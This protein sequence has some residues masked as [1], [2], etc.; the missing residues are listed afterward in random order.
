MARVWA[1]ARP[2]KKDGRCRVANPAGSRAE[3]WSP[4]PAAGWQC[5]VPRGGLA[6]GRWPRRKSQAA[7]GADLGLGVWIG[8]V[9]QGLAALVAVGPAAVHGIPF[10][11]A[12]GVARGRSFRGGPRRGGSGGPF[13]EFLVPLGLGLGS[14]G[15]FLGGTGV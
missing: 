6:S 5:E 1:G 14:G 15:G 10:D 3:P 7:A 8:R 2:R 11:A 13:V 12:L 4:G 9:D